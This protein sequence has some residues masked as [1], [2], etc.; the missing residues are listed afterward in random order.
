[1]ALT[2]QQKAAGRKSVPLIK[3]IFAETPPEAISIALTIVD[4][5]RL[6]FTAA[7][8]C[9]VGNESVVY[10]I[11]TNDGKL[12][13][14]QDIDSVYR[15]AVVVAGALFATQAPVVAM[16]VNQAVMLPEES[17][18][19]DPSEKLAKEKLKLQSA[20]AATD[21]KLVDI[22][23]DIAAV[24]SYATGTPKEQAYYNELVSEQ[25][26]MSQL[27]DWYTARIAEINAIL[28]P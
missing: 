23:V 16:I 14:Y 4:K 27:A 20:K 7:L 9:Q 2:T 17:I 15:T 24:A 26:V 18:S 19:G 11:A 13:K 8:T 25:T 1:M 10:D 5:K 3:A 21:A 22:G 6:T 28:T 12:K